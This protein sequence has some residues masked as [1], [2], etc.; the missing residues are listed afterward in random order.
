VTGWVASLSAAEASNWEICRRDNWFGTGA[1]R[2]SKVRVG[3]ELYVRRSG[4]GPF[5]YCVVTADAERVDDS[6]FVPWIPRDKYKYVWPIEIVDER[7]EPIDV[8][9]A[10]LHDLA[11]IGGVPA[12]QLPPIA[13][14]RADAVRDLFRS[15]AQRLVDIDAADALRRELAAI[16][17]EHDAR[18]MTQRAIRVRQ[19]QGRFRASLL[20]AYGGRCCITE[21]DVEPALEAAHITP[22]RGE[23]TNKVWNGLLLRADIHTLFDLDRLTVL[24]EGVV[25]I[26]PELQESQYASLDGGAVPPPHESAPPPAKDVLQQHNARCSWLETTA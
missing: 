6:S 3:D 13:D 21:C 11:E 1:P 10:Q 8:P 5:A 25:R 2:G 16:K 9:W 19:G 7:A 23:H 22:Y 17:N 26:A 4:Q 18:V 20:A 15:G 12:S 14:H 24:P